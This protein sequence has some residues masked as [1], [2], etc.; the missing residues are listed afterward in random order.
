MVKVVLTNKLYLYNFKP[1]KKVLDYMSEHFSAPNPKKETMK[2]LGKRHFYLDDRIYSYTRDPHIAKATFGRGD[3]FRVLEML[4]NFGIPHE[5]EVNLVDGD[6]VDY[7]WNKDFKLRPYQEEVRNK[8]IENN[9]ILVVAAGC[10][11]SETEFFNGE[12]WKKI[13]NYLK[14]DKVL[15]YEKSGE[16][17]LVTPE[18]YHKYTLR[19]GEKMTLINNKSNQ[20]NQVLSDNHNFVYQTPS[21]KLHKEPFHKIKEKYYSNKFGFRGRIISDFRF[22]GPGMD[23]S[24]DMIKLKLA[25]YGDAN[26]MTS[27]DGVDNLRFRLKKNR[28][29]KE[30]RKLLK[31]NKIDYREV[32]STVGGFRNFYFKLPADTRK[33]DKEWYNCS[34]RQLK[35]IAENV[36]K[37][38]GSIDEKGR[39]SWSTT[40]K[41]DADFIQFAFAAVGYPATVRE[42]DRVGRKYHNSKYTRKSLEYDVH[43]SKNIHRRTTLSR[44][45]GSYDMMEDYIPKDNTKYCF[46]VPSGMLVLRRGG[47]IFITG[48][49]GKTIIGMNIIKTI[50]KKS[51]WITHT[52]D[53]LNQSAKRCETTLGIKPGI[54]GGGKKETDK[55]VT[56]ATVQTLVRNHDLIEEL[57]KK[58][59]VL[60]VDEAHHVP[61]SYFEKVLSKFSTKRMFG[62]TATPTR[63][64]GK[65][66]FM[67]SAIG[68]KVVHIDRK[69]L[70]KKDNLIIPRLIPIY[71]KFDGTSNDLDQA[72]LDIG[73]DDS[74]WLR[75]VENLKED[76]ERKKLIA[77]TISKKHNNKPTLVLSEWVQYAEDLI[78]L[79]K[80]KDPNLIIEF[81][82]GSVKKSE[83]ERM[84]ENFEKNKIDILFATKIAREGLDLPNINNLFLTT[85][86]KGDSKSGVA[87]GTALEQEIGRAMRP[88]PNNPDKIAKVFDF[89]D[90]SNGILKNQWYTR[91]RTYKRLKI[92][93]PNKKRKKQYQKL[94][95]MFPGI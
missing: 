10:V 62:L 84:L 5:V 34:N 40:V 6:D 55:D 68:P 73:G 17:N 35:I 3:Y 49:S 8:A 54:I 26:I 76:Q 33:F 47:R 60:I 41:S 75:L 27:I 91:R 82:H 59:G 29:K 46:T 1:G 21:G 92:K 56:I 28:K 83:R 11:D 74:G 72:A 94:N 51:V 19:K 87:D 12:K 57:N 79:L 90:Y 38:D 30:L 14:T 85:P 45:K 4:R 7:S 63:K 44:K 15:Q 66:L 89:V 93:V 13:S 64:D 78:K 61:T 58:C 70:Y 25:I 23:I 86:R 67:Y 81:A 50:G 36:L 95:E 2:R 39:R 18:K 31:I 43:I 16:A 80:E 20:I 88:D 42:Y 52:K 48:N 69:V 53:L 65:S 77:K 71:T 22:D 32:G 37:W 24:D 9:G